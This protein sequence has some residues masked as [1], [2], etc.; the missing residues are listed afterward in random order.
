MV[1]GKMGQKVETKIGDV[2]YEYGTIP[3]TP[4]PLHL[5]LVL[6]YSIKGARY[7]KCRVLENIFF[8]VTSFCFLMTL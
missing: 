7:Q 8:R 2:T 5:I 6:E 1:T 3:K 4:F